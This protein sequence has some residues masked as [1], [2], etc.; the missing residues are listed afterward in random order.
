M[1]CG[2]YHVGKYISEL[3]VDMFHKQDT[4]HKES[5][6]LAGIQELKV[7]HRQTQRPGGLKCECVSPEI[8]CIFLSV[9]EMVILQILVPLA[10]R[11]LKGIQV[12]LL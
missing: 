5:R 11:S 7:P 9:C 6:C 12:K 10:P 3:T 2:L 4:S 1:K 8:T